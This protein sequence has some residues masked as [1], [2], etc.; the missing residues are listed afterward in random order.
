MMGIS[1]Q[2]ATDVSEILNDRP[3]PHSN[4]NDLWYLEPLT[5]PNRLG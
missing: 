1:V 2:Y 3:P 4:S 5:S